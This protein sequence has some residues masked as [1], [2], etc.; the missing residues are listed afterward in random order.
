MK[1]SANLSLLLIL[2]IC[3]SGLTTAS[4]YIPPGAWP[5]GDKGTMAYRANNGQL[6]NTDRNPCPNVRYYA[7]RAA[8][9]IYLAEKSQVAF[10]LTKPSL[11]TAVADTLYRVDMKLLGGRKVIP[12]G[13]GT[14]ADFSHYFIDD[15]SLTGVKA[16]HRVIYSSVYDSIDVHFHHGTSGPRISF[17]IR[18]GGDP[19]DIKLLFAGQDSIAYIDEGLNLYLEE[20]W[21][22]F[23]QAVAYQD[24]DGEVVPLSWTAT[25]NEYAEDAVEFVFDTYDPELPLIL[26]I[27]YPPLGGGGGGGAGSNL[28]WSTTVG[29]D[30]TEPGGGDYITGGDALP[31]GDLIVTG[32][33]GDWGFP[34][35]PGVTPVLL[36]R[37]IYVSRFNYAPVRWSG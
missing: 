3:Y 25:Y 7:E 24:D 10:V 14:L 16:F 32:C 13:D 17:V 2:L 15:Y 23:K 26:E 8:L 21:I 6:R 29:A 20:Q 36:G 1:L 22:E 28:D 33:T 9:G 31:D 37:D 19:A 4:P 12:A 34:A 30:D 27:G 11:D 5:D 18:P 35:N